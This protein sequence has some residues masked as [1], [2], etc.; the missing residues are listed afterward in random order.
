[1]KRLFASTDDF[2]RQFVYW[3]SRISILLILFFLFFVALGGVSHKAKWRIE[4]IDILGATVVSVDDVRKIVKEKLKGNYFFVYSRENSWLFPKSEIKRTLLETFPRLADAVITRYDPNTIAINLSERKPY[5]L[6]CGVEPKETV[7]DCWFV[8]SN[9][10]VFDKAPVFS[11]GVYV[12]LYARL[13]EKN[14]GVP[15]GAR[16]PNSRFLVADTFVKLASES[17]GKMSSFSIMENSEM[18]VVIYESTKYPFISGSTIR[19]LGTSKPEILLK[20]LLLAIPAQFPEN[21]A[22]AKKLLYIDM[23]FGDKVIF[24]FQN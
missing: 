5:A 24:G 18:E 13:M 14:A 22:R 21:V 9:G 10:F 11:D 4:K 3:L 12:E 8:D 16:I 1:M 2:R 15:I 7:K 19:F 23:R 20:K 17:I 6:W